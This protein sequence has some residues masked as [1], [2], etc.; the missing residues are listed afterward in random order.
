MRFNFHSFRSRV[1]T[2]SVIRNV[3]E[4]G[5]NLTRLRWPPPAAL[6]EAIST[7]DES[8]SSDLSRWPIM[9][10]CAA[11]FFELCRLK[12]VRCLLR[13]RKKKEPVRHVFETA[14]ARGDSISRLRLPVSSN[15]AAHDKRIT[16]GVSW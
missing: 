5:F 1:E 3:A 14:T 9:A 8:F 6:T 13:I 2:A 10:S 15:G 4:R 12:S 11:G 16:T 7:A